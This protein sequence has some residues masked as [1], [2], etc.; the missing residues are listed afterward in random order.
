MREIRIEKVVLNVGVGE[1]GDKLV[2]AE[3]VLESVTKQKPVR[4]Y[5]K[6]AVREWGVKRG[7]PIGCMVTLRGSRAD[8]VLKR[9]LDAVERRIKKDSF[10]NGGNFSFGIKEHI[11]IPGISYDPEIGIFGMD[12]CVALA[13][14]GY[15]ISRRRHLAKSIP[16]SHRITKEEAVNF[17]ITK[18]GVQVV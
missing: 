17:M 10:D 9:I 15:R 11:D 16:P 2:K 4:T 13:R 8:E 14:P 7:A 5:A 3:K 1:G 12:V 18:F 6:K